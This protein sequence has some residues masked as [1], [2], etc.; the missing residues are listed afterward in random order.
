METLIINFFFF[1]FSFLVEGKKGG[2]EIEIPGFGDGW[3]EV[4]MNQGGLW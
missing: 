1:F 3:M 2:K 4:R